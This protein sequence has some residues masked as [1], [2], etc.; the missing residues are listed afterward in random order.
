MT[1]TY[2][3]GLILAALA[4]AGIVLVGDAILYEHPEVFFG[5]VG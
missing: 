4:G 1:R 2:V 5:I 3:L